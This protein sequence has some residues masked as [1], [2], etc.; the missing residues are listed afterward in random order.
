MSIPMLHGNKSIL[1]LLRQT[2]LDGRWSPWQSGHSYEFNITNLWS[3]S[4]SPSPA[5]S[6]CIFLSFHPVLAAVIS[7]LTP[8]QPMST[9]TFSCNLLQLMISMV[10]RVS[11]WL[12]LKINSQFDRS[13]V[14]DANL[15]PSSKFFF[16]FR[17]WM[18]RYRFDSCDRKNVWIF[19]LRHRT[20]KV[21]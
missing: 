2:P 11:G 12:T 15:S 13:Q 16:F 14:L 8:R 9:F 20:F 18:Y 19:F 7:A 10:W 21:L 3:S 17:K 4:S 6:V 1:V 5:F